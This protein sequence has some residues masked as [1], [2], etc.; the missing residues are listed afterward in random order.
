MMQKLLMSVCAVLLVSACSSKQG[1]ETYGDETT[2][3]WKEGVNIADLETTATTKAF[4]NETD[5]VVY[6]AL[7]S[8][9]LDATAKADLKA[10]AA[11]LKKNPKAL[12][13]VEGRCDER[14]TREYNLALGDRRANIARSYLIANGVAAN[15]IKTISYGKDKPVVLGSNEEAWAKNRSATTVA[16]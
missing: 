3:G 2:G 13:V 4:H 11:W 10:Q 9:S 12:I 1:F 16:Y 5:D 15:R 14:G 6:F 8:S 7:N